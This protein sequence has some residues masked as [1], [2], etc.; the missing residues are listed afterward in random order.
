MVLESFF[1]FIGSLVCHQI[2]ERTLIIDKVLLP[3]CARDTG[4][5]I[6]VI[7]GIV[8]L[9]I[10]RR[11]DA[12]WPPKVGH[13]LI[14][15]LMMMP[16]M[17]DGA[18][19]YLGLRHSDNLTRLITGGFFGFPLAVFLTVARNYNPDKNSKVAPFST[20]GELVITVLFFVSFLGLIYKGI[21]PWIVVNLL[22]IAGMLVMFYMIS[23]SVVSLFGLKLKSTRIAVSLLGLFCILGC[24]YLLTR[25]VFWSANAPLQLTFLM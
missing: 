5:Y 18:T 3:I 20:L 10:R 2:Q 13:A 4:I 14:L 16:M 22:L 1:R 25:F 11:L 9:A 15:I 24:L 17:L 12:D 19:S 6:G 8:F 21:I 23:D 7:I